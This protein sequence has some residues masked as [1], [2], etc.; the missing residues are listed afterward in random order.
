MI[1]SSALGREL[2]GIRTTGSL[3]PSFSGRNPLQSTILYL[4]V[5]VAAPP[6]HLPPS[7]PQASRLW[8]LASM[9]KAGHAHPCASGRI[10]S[11]WSEGSCLPQGGA[12]TSHPGGPLPSK[13]GWALS[14]FVPRTPRRPLG[15]GVP[16]CQPPASLPFCPHLCPEALQGPHKTGHW[17]HPQFSGVLLGLSH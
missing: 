10:G 15:P 4:K 7:S 13:E 3:G 12:P 9:R 16:A 1:R 14:V 17:K 11:W 5:S 6:P 8:C 2:K